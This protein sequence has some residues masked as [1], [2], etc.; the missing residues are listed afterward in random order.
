M[1]AEKREILRAGAL[2]HWDKRKLPADDAVGD[3]ADDR[4]QRLVQELRVHQ[5]ELEAQNEA[6]HEA[7]RTSE[8]ALARY[9]ELYDFAPVGYVSLDHT[10]VITRANHAAVTLLHSMSSR[11]DSQRLA[12]FIADESLPE[13]AV[14]LG[15]ILG[16]ETTQCCEVRLR[17]VAG[18]AIDTV[19][20]LEGRAGVNGQDCI[21]AIINTT[22]RKRAQLALQQ[23]KEE[24]E[25]A[26]LAKSR[27]LAAASHDLRQPLQTL[28]LINGVMARRCGDAH[29]RDLIV[30]QDQALEVMS[31]MLNSLL[32]IN[33]IEAGLTTPDPI[34]FCLDPLLQRL[35]R[36]FAF[37]AGTG[38]NVWRVVPSRQVVRSDPKLLEQILRNLLSNAFKYTQHGK[39]L[40]GCRRYG[41]QL[42]IEVW[43]NGIG[44]PE[45]QIEEIFKEFV[46]IEPAVGQ[47]CRGLGLG[48]SI[49]QRQAALLDHP[50]RVHSVLGRGS[51]FSIELPLA[52]VE[53]LPAEIDLPVV[54]PPNAPIQQQKILLVEDDETISTML[55]TLFLAEGAAAVAVTDGRNLADFIER[56]SVE[57]DLLVTDYSLPEGLT[58]L[59][60]VATVRAARSPELPAILLTGDI[61]TETLRRIAGLSGC[62]HLT[63]PVTIAELLRAA[64][65]LLSRSSRSVAVGQPGATVFVID[66]D[67]PLCEALAILLE[68]EGVAVE[69]YPHAEAF[70]KEFDPSR[71]GCLLIDAVMPGMGGLELLRHLRSRNS[72][73]PAIVMTGHGDV[74]MAVTAMKAGAI[75]FVAK[76]VHPASLLAAI[77]RALERERDLVAESR[78]RDEALARMSSLTPREYDVLEQLLA[79]HRNK[80][81]A[82][83]LGISQRTVENHRAAVMRKTKSK[84]LFDLLRTVIAA[85]S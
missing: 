66:D 18:Q 42:R 24:A 75:D 11:T 3:S 79:G 9:T 33:Q 15:R 43:D 64:G 17:P 54:V 71:Q 74:A 25:R 16:G 76:P 85:N 26:N 46:Q 4:L 83:C 62:I 7:R 1:T 81:I 41:S 55:R 35:A 77:G 56:I 70:L 20:I 53:T 39:V 82:H 40:L 21:V 78:S 52:A 68:G 50:L 57:I 60:V 29:L 59:D 13:F 61:S 49:V 80:V 8:V 31:G 38:G 34:G 84:A 27:F 19:V 23:A 44:I 36:D 45:D 67:G 47:P 12:A 14:F 51:V 69:L 2:H 73:L 32:D 65:L 5:V 10:G 30:S 6:L 28:Y 37:Q 72:R 58:G 22:E 48:L 63:K